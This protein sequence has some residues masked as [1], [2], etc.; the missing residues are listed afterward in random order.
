MVRMTVNDAAIKR[1][2]DICAQVEGCL[3]RVPRAH[4]QEGSEFFKTMFTLPPELGCEA[5]GQSSE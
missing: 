2:L 1:V 5:D 4:F 3:F